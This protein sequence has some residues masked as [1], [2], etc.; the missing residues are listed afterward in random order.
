MTVETTIQRMFDE[1]PMLFST[2]KECYDHLFCVIGNAYKWKRGQ[3]VYEGVMDGRES[4]AEEEADYATQH[5]TAKQSEENI[6]KKEEYR[7]RVIRF[8][9]KLEKDFNF[10]W[11]PICKYS[12][13]L[14]VPKDIKPDWKVAVEECKQML[15]EDGI[16]VEKLK[17]EKN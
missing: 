13:I 10:N 17:H 8:N 2:R 3:L 12:A 1:C 5:P 7:Q 16:D 14:N 6:R 11:Y 4:I 15:K 9:P